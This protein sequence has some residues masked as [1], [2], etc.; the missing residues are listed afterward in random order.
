MLLKVVN[1]IYHKYFR[2]TH[3]EDSKF[4]IKRDKG[5][6][7]TNNKVSCKINIRK[8]IEDR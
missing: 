8:V 5:L 6:A 3:K 2:H 1:R 4:S 7:I